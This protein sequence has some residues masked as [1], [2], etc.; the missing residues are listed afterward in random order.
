MS[1]EWI[2]FSLRLLAF[3][4]TR[5]LYKWV[6]VSCRIGYYGDVKKSI[7][8]H[9]TVKN[10]RLNENSISLGSNLLYKYEI[11]AKMLCGIWNRT[12]FYFLLLLGSSQNGLCMRFNWG[13]WTVSLC[14]QTYFIASG[15]SQGTLFSVHWLILWFS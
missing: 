11:A 10:R 4:T 12:K 2:V 13:P 7:K 9:G 8:C 1:C 3:C 14:P 15:G 5:I 6:T